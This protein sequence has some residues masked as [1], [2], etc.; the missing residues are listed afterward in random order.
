MSVNELNENPGNASINTSHTIPKQI[1]DIVD[2]ANSVENLTKTY[3]KQLHLDTL[4]TEPKLTTRATQMF[5]NI[6]IEGVLVHG[7]QD[8]G[9]EIK[10]MPLNVYDQLNMKLNG[11]LQLKSCNDIKVVGYTKQSV[12]IVGRIAMTCTHANMIKKCLFYVTDITDNKV[13]LGLNFCRAFNL[14]KVICDENCVSKQVTI[15]AINDFPKG[16]DVPNMSATPKVLPPVDVHLK[17]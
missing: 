7:K 4:D 12:S 15:D 14:V 10:A 1:V 9:A 6:E 3:R 8:T 11:G 17:L 5:S 2:L 16:L 13:I